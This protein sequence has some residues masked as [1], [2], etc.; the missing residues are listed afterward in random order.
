MGAGPGD[1]LI[2]RHTV[3]LRALLMVADLAT[4]V[5]IF[6]VVA[7][8]RF[9][10]ASWQDAIAQAT[11]FVWLGPVTYA[12]A[13]VL[14]LWLRGLYRLR[15]RWSLRREA[16]DIVSAAVILAV[17]TFAF[18]FLVR[19]GDVSRSFL[20]VLF[21]VQAVVTLA[22][23]AALR[24]AFE[25]VRRRGG[26]PRFVLIVGDGQAAQDF[27]DRIEAHPTLG[28][29]VA[30]HLA[31]GS[32]AA[33]AVTR[34]VLGS[35]EDLESVLHGNVVDEV[36]ICL[37]VG[38]W[39]LVAP[40]TSV[41]E[42]EGRIVRIP[43]DVVG[44]PM[45]RGIVEDFDGRPVVSYVYGTDRALALMTKRCLDVILAGATLI[46]LSPLLV[47]VAAWVGLTDGRPILFRQTRV[48]LHGRTFT[49]YK[50]R[51]MVPDAEARLA[52]L[53][54]LNEVQ[55]GA[56]K[57]TRDPRLSRTGGALRRSSLDEVP[58][59][60]NVLRGEMSLVG[61]RPPLPDEVEGYDQ[62]HRRRLSM[63]PGM[64][65]LWQVRGRGDPVFD[66]WVRIDLEYIDRWSLWLDLVILLRTIPVML[67]QQGR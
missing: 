3:A 11:G 66:R 22:F 17:A 24:K 2:R 44:L 35:V 64:T 33:S 54:H 42:A 57:I 16:T 23:R 65:G 58:Q 61:P 43:M 14:V 8:L 1:R 51:T 47:V 46:V 37:P 13:W 50:F 41:C 67:S 49:L 29:R 10:G 20:L 19:L 53:R 15:A 62:W 27:A 55:G 48:G 56:F 34:P 52:D 59:L 6:V 40:I 60:V 45:E 9:G 32:G 28:L 21:P 38:S 31:E 7:G 63:K 39:G 26:N 4:A 36:V 18:L 30:G 5:A 12:G 25:A